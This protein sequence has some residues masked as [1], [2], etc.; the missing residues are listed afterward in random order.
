MN[1]T[2]L[3]SHRP[4]TVVRDGDAEYGLR[5]LSALHDP[6]VPGSADTHRRE[7]AP[8]LLPGEN[9][10]DFCWVR[11]QPVIAIRGDPDR[12]VPELPGNDVEPST[13][14]EGERGVGVASAAQSDRT[15]ASQSLKAL[16]PR[17]QRVGLDER[18]DVLRGQPLELEL[19]RVGEDLAPHDD[20]LDLPGVGGQIGV[21]PT[22]EPLVHAVSADFPSF[23]RC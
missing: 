9:G 1:E 7:F 16:P 21:A 3:D 15:Y 19:S 18:A 6:R 5:G 23:R 10:R 14:S 12:R 20:P 8:D 17:G 2:F 13:G 11:G 4:P 22:L